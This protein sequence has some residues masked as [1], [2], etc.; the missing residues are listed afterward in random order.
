MA[1][2]ISAKGYIP[3]VK[4]STFLEFA[5]FDTDFKK[6][7]HT[8]LC[9]V[10]NC[11]GR[12]CGI[13]IKRNGASTNYY[14]QYYGVIRSMSYLIAIVS[15]VQKW[16]IK[17]SMVNLRNVYLEESLNNPSSIIQTFPFSGRWNDFQLFSG[18]ELFLEFFVHL[19]GQLWRQKR[20]ISDGGLVEGYSIAVR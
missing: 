20:R 8:V 6:G 11:F 12:K 18:G 9:Y 2:M 10:A 1:K 14:V 16:S 7:T 15:S 19:W 17:Y 13:P 3:L 5:Q 4:S